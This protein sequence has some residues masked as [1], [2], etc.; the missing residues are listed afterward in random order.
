MSE[1]AVNLERQILGACLLDGKGYWRIADIVAAEDFADLSCRALYATLVDLGRQGVELDAVTIGEHRPDLAMFAVELA[2]DAYTM[3]NL[4]AHAELLLKR[5][6]LRAW[7]AAR[8]RVAK[9]ETPEE[10]MALLASCRPRDAQA[11][12]PAKDFLRASM[13]QLT[14]RTQRTGEMVGL[15]SGL[16]E[17]DTLTTGWQPGNLIV[18]GARPSVGKTALALQFAAHAAIRQQVP[19]L[20]FSVE[21]SG[22]ELTDRLVSHV[23]RIPG[24]AIRDP[25]RMEESHWTRVTA[26]VAAISEAPMWVDE[27]SDLTLDRI[28]ARARQLDAQHRLGLIVIDYLGLLHLPRADRHDLAIGAMT[29]GLKA[30]AKALKVPVVLLCQLNREGVG[31]PSKKDLRDSGAIE[32]DADVILFLYRRDEHRRDH[33]TLVL[34]KQR[35][36]PCGDIELHSNMSLMRFDEWTGDLPAEETGRRS[37]GFARSAAG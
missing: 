16:P 29:R 26:A 1:P 4:K 8:Q 19:T 7:H 10:A 35:N 15:A 21:Q 14:E 37:R 17:L 36:G 22:V 2:N 30:L 18:L 12:K 24:E 31:R 13:A 33:T 34:D 6:V 28:A 9:A 5:S 11:V 23:G 27:S 3:G 25:V 32:Q 20:V